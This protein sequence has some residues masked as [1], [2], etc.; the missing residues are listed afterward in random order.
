[1]RKCQ[2][3][4]THRGFT[5]IE[6]LVVIAIIGVLIALLLPAVQA[7]REAARRSQCTNNLKQLGLAAHN[8]H[9]QSGCFPLMTMYPAASYNGWSNGWPLQLLNGL[10]QS[11]MFNAF[12]FVFNVY[13]NTNG[14]AVNSTV[15]WSQLAVLLCPSDANPRTNP[16]WGTLNYFGNAGGPGQIRTFSGTIIPNNWDNATS[17]GALPIAAIVDGTSN[18]ALFSERL[19]GFKDGRAVYPGQTQDAKRGEFQLSGY[20]STTNQGSVA[21]PPIAMTMIQKCSSLPG[22]QAS[23]YSWPCGW[24]WFVAYP[25]SMENSSYNHVG[26]PNTLACHA[27]NQNGW[28]GFDPIFPPSSNHSGGVNV[29]FA[30][31]SVKF[32]KDSVSIPTWWALG[33]RNG[34]EVVS[35]DAY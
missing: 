19:H 15:G 1:M 22:T 28:G 17:D 21:G 9:D 26:T 8:Y 18:T 23:S 35:A 12:N 20:N 27:S 32:I 30:D 4:S 33:T 3:G 2:G 16:P 13:D 14:T 31:G 10:E 7:A 34:S 11:S 5:L 6:L 25:A 24:V 29:A